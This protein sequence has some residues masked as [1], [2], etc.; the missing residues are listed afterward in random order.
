[1]QA[2]PTIS[3]SIIFGHSLTTRPV[4]TLALALNYLKVSTLVA[5]WLS[6]LDPLMLWNYIDALP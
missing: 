2:V 6:F 1:M 3:G 4:V 5:D